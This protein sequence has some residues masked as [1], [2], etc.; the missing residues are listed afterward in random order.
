[1][2]GAYLDLV[3]AYAPPGFALA[4]VILG[5]WAPFALI[6]GALAWISS[7]A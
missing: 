3:Q 1:M 4:A 5:L 7:R 2:I 6:Y